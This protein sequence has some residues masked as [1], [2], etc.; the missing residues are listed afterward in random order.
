VYIYIMHVY[1]YI[2]IH[3]YVVSSE[4]RNSSTLKVIFLIIIHIFLYAFLS[5]LY[6]NV[7]Y[8]CFNTLVCELSKWTSSSLLILK[9]SWITAFQAL[10][11]YGEE[12]GTCNVPLTTDYM[13]GDGTDLRLGMPLCSY[14]PVLY[15]FLSVQ[16]WTNSFIPYT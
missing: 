11:R 13:L 12:Y 10:I 3:I 8:I 9:G 5:G 6:G 15:H 4:A 16:Q 1:T 7:W 14:P 2:Y